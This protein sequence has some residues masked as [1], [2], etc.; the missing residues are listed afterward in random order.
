MD[1]RIRY[2]IREVN[3]EVDETPNA[4]SGFLTS[5]FWGSLGV[6]SMG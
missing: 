6:V 2:A 5:E 4:K 1:D 3:R